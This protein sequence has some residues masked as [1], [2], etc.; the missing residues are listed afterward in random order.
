VLRH[1]PTRWMLVATLGIALAFATVAC[2]DDDDSDVAE[3]TDT[4]SATEPPSPDATPTDETPVGPGQ[5][6]EEWSALFAALDEVASEHGLASPEYSAAHQATSMALIALLPPELPMPHMGEEEGSGL[7]AGIAA[8]HGGRAINFMARDPDADPMSI[9]Q[10]LPF[11]EVVEW[12]EDAARNAGW[13]L[14]SN[15]WSPPGAPADFRG[16]EFHLSG[17]GDEW[18]VAVREDFVT[19]IDYCPTAR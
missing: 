9:T 15:E 8:C 6:R 13:T 3:P 12:F 4:P 17:H 2:G 10:D 5:L 1:T 19:N 16:I 18:R 11:D 14:T 7:A